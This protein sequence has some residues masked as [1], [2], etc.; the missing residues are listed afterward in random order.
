MA[1]RRGLFLSDLPSAEWVTYVRDLEAA[2]RE[3]RGKIEFSDGTTD[4]Y[5]GTANPVILAIVKCVLG[6]EI[7]P[8]SRRV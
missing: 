4:S 1:T 3:I 2:L 6:E 8:E 7:T 5:D